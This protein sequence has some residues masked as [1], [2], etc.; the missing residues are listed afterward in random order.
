MQHVK[1]N[2]A[3]KG[4][5]PAWNVLQLLIWPKHVT[6]GQQQ[7]QN[8]AQNQPG[9]LVEQCTEPEINLPENFETDES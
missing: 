7:P 5:E 6:Q 2:M 8:I 3:D 1:I 4:L 9:N